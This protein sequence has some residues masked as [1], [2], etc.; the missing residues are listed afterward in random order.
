MQLVVRRGRVAGFPELVDIGIDA[1]RISAVQKAITERGR[2]EV[3]AVGNVVSVPFVDAHV[4]LD[5]VL[6]V[7]ERTQNL[8]GTLLE[9]IQR[10]AAIKPD[11]TEEDVRG[12]AREAILWEVAH[13]VQFIRSH[14]DV[15][16][17]SL[18]ALRAL[19]ALR[20]E[21]KDVVD[22]QLVAFPQEGVYAYADGTRLMEEA[23]A[24]GADVVGG[25]PHYEWTR[26][27]GLREL[28]FVFDLARRQG[29]LIDIH[30]DETDD[31][32]SRFL[33]TVAALTLRLELSGRVSASHTTAMHSYNGA[34]AFK[35]IRL[36]ARA[37][38]HIIANPVT[39][40]VLQGRFDTY[41]KR[42]GMTRI[43][44]LHEA[45]VNVCLG[46]DCIMDPWYP[47]GTG[48][49]LFAALLAV[50]LGHM[51]SPAELDAVFEM[52]TTHG[53]RSVTGG[54]PRRIAPGE[55][56]DLVIL[57]AVSP[58]EALRLMPV[59]LYVVRRGRI[60]VQSEPARI[61]VQTPDGGRTVR[62]RREQRSAVQ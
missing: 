41:P 31:D 8:S 15:C 37:G 26:E 60:V 52:V 30:C 29:R 39:N 20:E 48:S 17:P 22:L 62:F 1:G 10:W 5:A 57:D 49:M 55:P 33:E 43:K 2:E 54:V 28:E 16:D 47:L 59:P 50:H 4:H 9:G 24:V 58:V 42:R 12:R 61:T 56:A 32:Q 13:G 6:T 44:E 35:L 40:S 27:D 36:L 23:L 34:Y 51:T 3:D 14:V 19:V 25:I 53:Y 18:T 38:V 46:Y 45:G 21:L 7:P 11:L